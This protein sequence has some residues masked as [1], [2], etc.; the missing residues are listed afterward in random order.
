MIVLPSLSE[1]I[2]FFIKLAGEVVAKVFQAGLEFF[3]EIVED[4]MHVAHGLL[5]LP[6]VFLDLTGVN[7]VQED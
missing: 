6:F 4:G 1:N 3:L 2:T 5:R 7:K